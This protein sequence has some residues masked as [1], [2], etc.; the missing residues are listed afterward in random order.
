MR[1]VLWKPGAARHILA[2]ICICI[3]CAGMVWGA[4]NKEQKRS[5]I[6]ITPPGK[7]D[8]KPSFSKESEEMKKRLTEM[9]ENLRKQTVKSRK[10]IAQIS[11]RLKARVKKTDKNIVPQG[12]ISKDVANEFGLTKSVKKEKKSGIV[13]KVWKFMKN[14]FLKLLKILGI[15]K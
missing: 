14:I 3:L 6:K 5:P 10:E 1:N 11:E 15:K 13:V 4:K 9:R 8:V 2:S 7:I 12:N